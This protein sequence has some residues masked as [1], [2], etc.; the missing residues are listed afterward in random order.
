M[1][2]PRRGVGGASESVGG[3]SERVG[4]RLRSSE[5]CAGGSAIL[6][7]RNH[8]GLRVFINLG[9]TSGGYR[10]CGFGIQSISDIIFMCRG[11]TF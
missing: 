10:A 2:E 1:L 6:D 9:A 11:V 8:G 7:D 5:G 4:G 3:A